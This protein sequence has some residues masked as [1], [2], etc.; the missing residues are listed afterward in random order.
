[1]R[2]PSPSPAPS[3]QNAGSTAGTSTSGAADHGPRRLGFLGD[4]LQLPSAGHLDASS[5]QD[6]ISTRTRTR[7]PQIVCRFVILVLFGT[8]L[9]VLALQTLSCFALLAKV[10]SSSTLPG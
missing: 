6:L 7:V 10:R 1:M 3:A 4:I 9:S 5:S 8:T 2:S